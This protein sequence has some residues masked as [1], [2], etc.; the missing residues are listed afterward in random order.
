MT[1]TICAVSTP[2]GKGAVSIIRVSGDDAFE[3]CDKLFFGKKKLANAAS[4]SVHFGRVGNE[5]GEAIDECLVSVFVAPTSFTGENVCEIACHGG[6]LVTQKVLD[7]VIAA[8][9]RIAEPG[10]FT[11][12]AFLMGKLTLTQAESIKDVI[13]AQ[14]SAALE[15]ATKRLW[16]ALSK[17][18]E[19]IRRSLVRLAAA[20]GAAA[21]F[22]E[23]NAADFA[24]EDIRAILQRARDGIEKLLCGA[25][26]GAFLRNGAKVAIVG[27]PNT[28]KSSI[29]NAL[30]E[31]NRA[32][33]TAQPG[34][35]RDIVEE[36]IE[37]DGVPVCLG[38]TA[39]IRAADDAV[40]K[41][42]VEMA[43]EYIKNAA[44]C[45]FVT[46]AGRELTEEENELLKEIGDKPVITVANKTD[47]C[48]DE[49][50]NAVKAS[51][52]ERRGMEE[53]KSAISKALGD[54][55]QDVYIANERVRS[56]LNGA[57]EAICRAQKTIEGEFPEDVAMV[58]IAD[59]IELLGVSDGK[60]VSEEI[61]DTVFAEFCLGK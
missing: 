36:S 48:G 43:R 30:V 58:D 55:S 4:H 60:S 1:D 57:K 10:E 25:K 9:A 33:V 20:I 50:E 35:T 59:A 38:D 44:M 21:D 15:A 27:V 8:G 13:D 53:L 16:G 47:L 29:L 17:P 14:T 24:H 23:E 19:E 49:R 39:G 7:A 22:P 61:V 12:R 41:I 3:I 11:K 34:T 5:A 42:G 32:I 31:Q 56:S 52:L 37:I 51:A 40:E 28:G 46:E 2:R 45:I 18:I 54:S 26:R 6:I